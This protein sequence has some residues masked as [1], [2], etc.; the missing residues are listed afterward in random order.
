MNSSSDNIRG[1]S[2][3]RRNCSDKK[4]SIENRRSAH[5]RIDNRVS[6]SLYSHSCDNSSGG[7]TR[8]NSSNEINMISRSPA[9]KTKNSLQLKNS[10]KFDE[11][12][13]R[14]NALQQYMLEIEKN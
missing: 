2:K 9:L 13:L 10:G 12:D 4:L 14:L 7:Y 3:T 1:R 6:P 8:E 5:L 11:I